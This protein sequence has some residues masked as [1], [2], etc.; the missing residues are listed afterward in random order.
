MFAP[1]LRAHASQPKNQGRLSEANAWGESSYPPCGDVFKLSLQ[2][3]DGCIAAVG[4]EARACGPAVAFGSLATE[5]IRGLKVEEALA[6]DSF[7]WDK[8][9][10]GLPPAKVHV[11]L[12][13]LE[14]LHQ[15]LRVETNSGRK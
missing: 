10:G 1:V 4:F 3:E 14:A 8:A 6:R 2:I 5:S 7:F 13:F 12:L 15:A 11:I 9:A